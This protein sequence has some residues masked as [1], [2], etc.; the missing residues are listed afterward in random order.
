[1][2]INLVESRAIFAFCY[3]RNHLDPDAIFRNDCGRHA[4]RGLKENFRDSAD[5]DTR[6]DFIMSKAREAGRVVLVRRPCLILKY[7][8]RLL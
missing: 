5:E 4:K 2:F 3:S 7:G 6:T 8:P 1:M